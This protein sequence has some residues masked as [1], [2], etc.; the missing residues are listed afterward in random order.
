MGVLYVIQIVVP[1]PTTAA[2]PPSVLQSDWMDGL[3]DGIERYGIA[4]TGAATSGSGTFTT[5]FHFPSTA[6]ATA[7]ISAHKLSDPALV[8]DMTAWKA[9]YNIQFNHYF[10]NLSFDP[11]VTDIGIF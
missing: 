6:E 10:Y 11:T 1:G 2:F 9:L 3:I 7:W 4:G 8:A 5:M